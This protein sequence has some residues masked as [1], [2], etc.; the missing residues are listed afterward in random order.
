M[1]LIGMLFLACVNSGLQR[2]KIIFIGEVNRFY[3]SLSVNI[4]DN[5]T[6]IKFLLYRCLQS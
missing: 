5:R 6:C 1:P 4:L 2:W 3:P